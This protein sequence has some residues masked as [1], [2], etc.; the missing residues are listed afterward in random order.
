MKTVVLAGVL[1]VGLA[2][3]G[4]GPAVGGGQVVPGATAPRY[5][6]AG[7]KGSATLLLHKANGAPEAALS[8]LVLAPG[9][10]V[11]EHVHQDSVEIL[12]VET[13]T[14]R[15]VVGGQTLTAGPGDA[16]RIPAGV[17]HSAQVTS[18]F[19][20]LHTV[21]VYVGPGPEQRFATGEKMAPDTR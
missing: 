17:R 11:P 14:V 8:V 12:Y 3:A 10:V 20:P 13:G 9:A 1:A 15:M 19:E 16:I 5:V 6:I 4:S 2:A 21:Q 7:G 18:R